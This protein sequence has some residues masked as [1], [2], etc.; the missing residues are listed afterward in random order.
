MI[1][2][3]RRQAQGEPPLSAP[4]FFWP[5][6]ELYAWTI[7]GI[8]AE[9]ELTTVGV[10]KESGAI[11]LEYDGL[12][13]ELAENLRDFIAQLRGAGWHLEKLSERSID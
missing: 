6:N 10:M 11:C 3:Q 4:E 7:I 12:T 13:V 8:H 5:P 2:A 9:D 1:E